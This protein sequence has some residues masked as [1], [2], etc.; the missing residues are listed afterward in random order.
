MS[1]PRCPVFERSSSPSYWK[2]TTEI[3]GETS[4]HSTPVLVLFD[5]LAG[6][7]GV[8]SA[9]V[10]GA[11][12]PVEPRFRLSSEFVNSLRERPVPWGF[13]ILSEVVYYRT[14]SRLRP[15]GRQEA[16]ADTVVRVV[17]GVFS[18][19]KHWCRLMRL[20]W[21]DDFMQHL[22]QRMAEDIFHMRFLPPGRGLWAMG[23][24]TVYRHGSMALNNCAF[25]SVGDRLSDAA[26]WLMDA[27]MLGVGVGF[28]THRH[29]HRSLRNPSHENMGI[30][31]FRIPDSREGWVESVRRLI[32]SYEEPSPRIEFDYSEIRPAG[33]PI[34]GFGGIASGPE[35]LKR[36]HEQLRT[37]LDRAKRV[38]TRLIADVMNAIGCCVVA[39]NVRRSA[40]ICLGDPRDDVFLNLK[41][42]D[43][44]PER[45]EIGWLD[46]Q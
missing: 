21:D 33:A 6:Q 28:D 42:Y 37:F 45:A 16:W 2:G 27:L 17:E 25:V 20:P 40:E 9:T 30:E 5:E 1:K 32:A 41:N 19:R 22:A 10:G 13:P 3:L 29:T 38:D 46:E 34:R 26:A 35:P 11:M 12:L 43:R 31:V 18:I 15:D 39:G 24:E 14:Y 7:N 4:V 44:Y 36:L 23:T 8:V